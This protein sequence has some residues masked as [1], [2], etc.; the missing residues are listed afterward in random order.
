MVPQLPPRPPHPADVS[1][2]EGFRER[3]AARRKG[4]RAGAGI[5]S[6]G[7][8]APD[9]PFNLETFTVPLREWVAQTQTVAEIKRRFKQFLVSYTLATGEKAYDR[10]IDEMCS[11]NG[12]SLEVSY[13]HLSHHTPSLAIW[14][15]DVPKQ[16]LALFD[17][18]AQEV[19]LE[20]YDDYSRIHSEIYV[21]I[22]Q[23][24][25][26]DKLRELRHGHLNQLV[27]VSG[28]VTRRTGVFPQLKLVSYDCGRCG[29]TMGPFSGSAGGEGHVHTGDCPA[30]GASSGLIVNSERTQYRNFQK[31]TLQESPGSVPAG[32]VP[33]YKEVILLADLIDKAKPG[34]EIDVVGIYTQ[35]YDAMLNIRQGFPVFATLVEANFIKK[36]SDDHAAALLSDED[37]KEIKKL[38][39]AP[40]IMARLIRS[41]APSIY[42]N[43][44]MKRAV[45]LSLFG[46]R[47][48]NVNGKHRIRGD[49]NVLLLGDPGTAK[50][51]V[52]KYIEKI[53]PRAV[54]T[55]GKGASAVGLTASVHKDPLTGEFV[56]EGGALVLADMGVCLIVRGGGG[57]RAREVG[58]PTQ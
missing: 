58:T 41:I 24:P 9:E 7:D 46:G 39:G 25:L 34:E 3:D 44:P 54:Y 17:A 40:N 5:G 27:K 57:G 36:K 29:E 11:Q 42:G 52:L 2:S 8:G 21:R 23:L 31:V 28:V 30:C 43:E 19:V 20:R 37:R 1:A 22:T 49:I 12:Q 33:R 6:E 53:A 14:L 10:Q 32:R 55:T 15:A 48:K 35:T 45:A 56:L 13:L 26:D 38:A 18:V 47:E 16:I 50:S 4:L 51:Q